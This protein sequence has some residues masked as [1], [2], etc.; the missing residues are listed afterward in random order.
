MLLEIQL[1]KASALLKRFAIYCTSWSLCSWCL[2][3][4][5][6]GAIDPTANVRIHGTN[7]LTHT[8]ALICVFVQ[9]C[10]CGYNFSIPERE[11]EREIYVIIAQ[12]RHLKYL[13]EHWCT[14]NWAGINQ[15]NKLCTSISHL[16]DLF[17]PVL[18]YNLRMCFPT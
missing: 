18:L 15:K 4:C 5:L 14:H 3:L 7:T 9:N 2:D 1:I 8:F 16:D 6:G 10:L 11:R 13:N 17:S 12:W